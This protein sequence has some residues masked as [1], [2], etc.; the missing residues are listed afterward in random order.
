[1]TP[2]PTTQDKLDLMAL[3]MEKMMHL[4][5][6][7]QNQIVAQ[8]QKINS[9]ET[10]N[11]PGTTSNILP[12]PS[13]GPL[14]TE[15]G[16]YGLANP[17]C[18]LPAKGTMTL[19]SAMTFSN[20]GERK[21]CKFQIRSSKELLDKTEKE[22]DQTII[23]RFYRDNGQ[24]LWSNLQKKSKEDLV[25]FCEN[26]ENEQNIQNELFEQWPQ[27][28]HCLAIKETEL[29]NQDE[30]TGD[31]YILNETLCETELALAFSR[32]PV[33]VKREAP[34]THTLYNNEF[35][36]NAPGE[37][38]TSHSAPQ[39]RPQ[40]MANPFGL[41]EYPPD[42]YHDHPKPRYDLPRTSHWE[43]DSRIKTIV[44]NM[45]PLTMDGA[46]TNKCLLR[47]FIRLENEFGYDPSNHV[48]MSALR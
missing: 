46:A 3:Q 10:A 33:H 35:S 28:H 23:I 26:L 42:S 5:G 38:E 30:E 41:S 18:T 16:G 13:S 21:C 9:L 24:A 43:E 19:M 31:I 44:D 12:P 17:S 11:F 39:R 37:E 34:S 45:H 48:K 29:P 27:K 6:Q 25:T 36:R 47:F 22:R 32:Q 2:N 7:M 1:M 8:H 4:L 40:P 14:H 20:Q 15:Q